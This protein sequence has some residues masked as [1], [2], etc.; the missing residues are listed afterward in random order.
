MCGG[1]RITRPS[2]CLTVRRRAAL[3][4]ALAL[5]APIRFSSQVVC[6]CAVCAEL[7]CCG[8]LLL[9]LRLVALLCSESGQAAT[10]AQW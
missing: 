8:A 4:P 9:L 10:S 5:A 2:C 3:A 7:V 1:F 6:V